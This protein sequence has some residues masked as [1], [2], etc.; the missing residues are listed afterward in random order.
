MLGGVHCTHRPWHLV[1]CVTSTRHDIQTVYLTLE[2]ARSF[3]VHIVTGLHVKVTVGQQETLQELEAMSAH[4][5]SLVKEMEISASYAFENTTNRVLLPHIPRS[6]S[7]RTEIL[8][9][10]VVQMMI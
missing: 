10:M 6:W 5:T 1:Y 2:N 8:T 3:Y 9:E 7:S 4:T